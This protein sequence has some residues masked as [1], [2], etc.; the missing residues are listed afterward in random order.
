MTFNL[1]RSVMSAAALI[2][3]TSSAHALVV[4]NSTNATD[5][6]KALGGTGVTI[7]NATLA[8]ATPTASGIF[9][10][11]GNIGFDQGILL[12]TGLTSCA[13]GI[14]NGAEC[15]GGGT[16][17]SL[18]F[19]FTSTTGNIFFNY[20]FASEEYNEYVGSNFNDLFEL[21]LNGVNIALVP[22]DKGVV[23]INNVNNGINAAYYR[24][25][26]K[27]TIATGYDGL[28]T[29]LNA[30]AFGLVGKNTFEF[31][32]Q[33]RGD[34]RLDSGVFIQGGTF[35]ADPVGVPEPGSLALLGL[36]LAG[37]A[38]AKRKKAA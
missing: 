8:S 13:T 38:V 1:I 21:K 33:D 15:S 16:T 28:T 19:D 37:L 7:S 31:L 6:A 2:L 3:A 12:T 17:T 26:A 18:K 5:L 30:K 29:V 20:V 34:A 36:G 32:I 35:A 14:N 11:G 23:S 22:G 25:N 9:T 4:S 24:D 27:N 10:K